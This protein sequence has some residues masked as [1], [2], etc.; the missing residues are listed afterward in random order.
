MFNCN[1]A[2]FCIQYHYYWEKNITFI[3]HSFKNTWTEEDKKELRILTKSCPFFLDFLSSIGNSRVPPNSRS[4]QKTKTEQQEK[5]SIL[6]SQPW[7]NA[8]VIS[9]SHSVLFSLAFFVSSSCF[10]QSQ[11]LCP[12]KQDWCYPTQDTHIPVKDHKWR[13][14]GNKKKASPRKIERN[15]DPPYSK[16]CIPHQLQVARNC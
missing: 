13:D 11:S 12:G 2:L 8:A 7:V 9:L 3:S 10:Q 4:V 1:L 5:K 16:M 14:T 6:K 15:T